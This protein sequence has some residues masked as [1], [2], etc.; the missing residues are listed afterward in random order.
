[1]IRRP[2]RSTRTDT[3]FPYT[4]IFRSFNAPFAVIGFFG[5][6]PACLDRLHERLAGDTDLF[7]CFPSGDTHDV[8]R[9]SVGLYSIYISVASSGG[10]ESGARTL[11]PRPM[12]SWDSYS[13]IPGSR[14]SCS[15]ACR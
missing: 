9:C 10:E 15:V 3:L 12:T 7:G 13:L 4:T 2:P 14:F 1:M 11:F 5:G 8:T 6:N